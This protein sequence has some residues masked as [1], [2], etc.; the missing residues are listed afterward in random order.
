MILVILVCIA[1]LNQGGPSADWG[2]ILS[3][4]YDLC[5]CGWWKFVKVR[6]P[7][8]RPATKLN[9]VWTQKQNNK[10]YHVVPSCS[11]FAVGSPLQTY[12]NLINWISMICVS[13]RI[14]QPATGKLTP[15]VDKRPGTNLGDFSGGSLDLNVIK[16]N[17]RAWEKMIFAYLCNKDLCCSILVQHNILRFQIL[18]HWP[19]DKK[20]TL[21]LYNFTRKIQSNTKHCNHQQGKCS[22]RSKSPVQTSKQ[23]S[24]DLV[25]SKT[26]PPK[27]SNRNNMQQIT[28]SK[29]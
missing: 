5:A 7:H 13:Y 21:S 19:T 12:P 20:E 29:L 8:K 23:E 25:K 11:W 1:L 22:L 14:V 17:W 26:L 18:G 3:V 24:L 27:Y 16:A 9:P 15:E 6:Y 4:D 28:S 2:E 10:R